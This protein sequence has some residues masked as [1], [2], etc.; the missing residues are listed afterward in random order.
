MGNPLWKYDSQK[1]RGNPHHG[2]GDSLIRSYCLV[3]CVATQ[4]LPHK[5]IGVY[6]NEAL[7]MNADTR[8]TA[9][10]LA[11]GRLK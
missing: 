8:A 6:T 1:K 5:E 7:N 4:G 10:D 11:K 3:N 2:F 9:Q